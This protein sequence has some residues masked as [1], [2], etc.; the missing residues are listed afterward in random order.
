MYHQTRIEEESL[1]KMDRINIT[2]MVMDERFESVLKLMRNLQARYLK[3]IAFGKRED[4]SEAYKGAAMG[5][6]ATVAAIIGEMKNSQSQI[7]EDQKREK[8]LNM[9]G[10]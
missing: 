4:S 2:T 10:W 3:N 8:G 6:S 9:V 7:A 1:T 5:L